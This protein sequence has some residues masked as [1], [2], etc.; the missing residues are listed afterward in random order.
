MAAAQEPPAVSL[1]ETGN[2]LAQRETKRGYGT[3]CCGA[4]AGGAVIKLS[5]RAGAEIT[6]Y[7]FGSLLFYNRLEEILEKKSYGMVASFYVRKLSSQR[8]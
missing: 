8:R 3:Q 7:D 6:N 5:P 1:V 2:L 4:G